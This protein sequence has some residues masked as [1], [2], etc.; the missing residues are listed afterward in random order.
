MPGSAP[1]SHTVTVAAVVS[2]PTASTD[3]T[4]TQLP[5][6]GISMMAVSGWAGS[7]KE[8][9]FCSVSVC[10]PLLP[11]GMFTPLVEVPPS[12]EKL[13]E[14]P[15]PKLRVEEL[16]G[17]LPGGSHRAPISIRNLIGRLEP[18]CCPTKFVL[19]TSL[20]LLGLGTD[21]TPAKP[22]RMPPCATVPPTDTRIR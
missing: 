10:W 15:V 21:S 14:P 12:V 1:T 22:S 17:L 11:P 13:R 4:R 19:F 3:L 18:S 20:S 2:V 6:T 16:Q 8:G 5:K 7:L 9:H